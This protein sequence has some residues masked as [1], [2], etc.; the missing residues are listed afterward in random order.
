MNV[1]FLDRVVSSDIMSKSID[2]SIEK[3]MLYGYTDLLSN[4]CNPIGRMTIRQAFIDGRYIFQPCE[5]KYIDKNTG[6]YLIY[7]QAISRDMKDV[8]EINVSPAMDRILFN[9]IN[10]TLFENFGHLIHKSSK[11]YQKGIGIGNIVTELS[12]DLKYNA[13]KGSLLAVKGDFKKF[14][15]TVPIDLINQWL[16][17]LFPNDCPVG[18]AVKVFY[19]DNRVIVNGKL[20]ER[21]TS[22][23]Q[24]CAL[25]T[26]LCNLI[27]RDVDKE[28]Y[29]MSNGKYIRY[30]DDFL[31]YSDNALEC[32]EVMC[33]R[34]NELKLQI[35]PKKTEYIKSGDWFTFLGF[36]INEEQITFSKKTIKTFQKEIRKR[37]VDLIGQKQAD[38]TRLLKMNRNQ[39]NKAIKNI[40]SYLYTSFDKNSNN[41][42]WG[43]YF[44]GTVTVEEDI[45]TLDTYI[46]DC[47]RAC[48]TGRTKIGYLG[49][50]DKVER[51]PGRHVKT[52]YERTHTDDWDLIKDLGTYRSMIHMWKTKRTNAEL[53]NAEVR[54]MRNGMKICV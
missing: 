33:K 24:G 1:S 13:S 22:L 12:A 48:Y 25:A 18:K 49:S 37:T 42:G 45:K 28:I 51:S 31:I 52:N 10:L 2:K 23:T 40:N 5:I 6:N 4:I 8:R 11:A 14:F 30:S 53:F 36:K 27:L 15:D 19:N 38:G 39:L 20:V 26:T 35:N 34:L 17:I 32:Y 29:E 54:Q 50:S 44:L 7:S 46:K 9:A 43:Q 16:D 47:L 21:Y 41:F 3:G